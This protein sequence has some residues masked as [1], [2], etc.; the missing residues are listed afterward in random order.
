MVRIWFRIARRMFTCDH[1]AGSIFKGWG[2][3]PRRV[4]WYPTHTKWLPV[5]VWI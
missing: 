2:Y 4:V 5:Y 1:C 3:V